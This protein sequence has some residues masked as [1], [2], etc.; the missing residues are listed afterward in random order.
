MCVRPQQ[1]ADETLLYWP[2]DGRCYYRL[3]QGPCYIG[4]LLDIGSDGLANCTVSIS[5]ASPVTHTYINCVGWMGFCSIW[6]YDER[7]SVCLARDYAKS[8]L[9]CLL[10]VMTW[11]IQNA[12]EQGSQAGNG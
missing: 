3:S 5:E 7:A 1:C 8:L 10:R 9:K 6:P 12:S 11:D 2:P 4:S